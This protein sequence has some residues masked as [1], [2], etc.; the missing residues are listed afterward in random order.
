MDVVT[1]EPMGLTQRSPKE[2][3]TKGLVIAKPDLDEPSSLPTGEVPWAI[4]G[5]HCHEYRLL[6]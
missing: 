4:V 2:F 3:T 6:R 1:S 5:G